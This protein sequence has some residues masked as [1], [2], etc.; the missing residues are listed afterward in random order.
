MK[1]LLSLTILTSLIFGQFSAPTIAPFLQKTDKAPAT[2]QPVNE[3]PVLNP[4]DNTSTRETA[5]PLVTETPVPATQTETPITTS[6]EVEVSM[7][8]LSVNPDFITPGGNLLLQW[9]IKGLPLNTYSPVLQITIPEGFSIQGKVEGEFDDATRILTI[10]VNALDGKIQLRA[11]P[12]ITDTTFYAVLLGNTTPLAE[13]KYFVPVHKQFKLDQRGGVIEDKEK[14]IKIEFPKDIFSE[15]T[16]VEIGAPSDEA[17]PVYS[18]L[19]RPF[20]IKAH[21]ELNNELVNK[22]DDFITLGVNYADLGIPENQAGDI[23]IAWYNEETDEWEALPSSVDKETQTVYAMTNHFTVFDI[24]VNTWQ[25]THVPTIDAFQVSNFTGAATYSLPI[26][27][28]PGPGGLQ[29]EVVLNYNSQVVDQSN[30]LAQA[31]WAGMGWS[32]DTG[33]IE[34]NT[35]GTY[36]TQDDTFFLNIR[37]VSSQ[38]VKDTSGNYHLSDENFWKVKFI[39]NPSSWELKDKT[40]NTYTFG[41]VSTM[42][43]NTGSVQG[44]GS[45]DIHTQEYRWDLTSVKNIF[46]KEIIY[47]YDKDTKPFK[48]NYFNDYCKVKSMPTDTAV[49][50]K[51]I[52]YANNRYQVRFELSSRSDYKSTWLSDWNHHSFMQR[53][54]S[55]IY[56]EQKNE[57]TGVFDI[58][59]RKYQLTYL[60]NNDPGIIWPGVNWSAGGKTATLSGVRQFGIGGSTALPG[61]TFTY[62]DNMHLT[63]A[64]NGYGGA[65]EFDY[66]LWEYRSNARNSQTVEIEFGTYGYPC[67]GNGRFTET[68]WLARPGTGSVVTCPGEDG[69]EDG[70]LQVRGIATAADIQ[71]TN[72]S[73]YG[74]NTS[75][76]LVRPGGMYK[77]TVSI[78]GMQSGMSKKVGLFDGTRDNLLGGGGPYFIQLPADASKVEPVVQITGGTASLGYFKF[79]LLTAVYRVQEKR[80]YDGIN[81]QPYRYT[82]DY[83]L[84]DVDSAKVNDANTSDGVCSNAEDC[85][86][87]TEQFSEF[88]GHGQVTETGPDGTKTITQFHQDDILK[89]R[90]VST[91]KKFD[92]ELLTSSDYHYTSV[93]LPIA[94]ITPGTCT[95]CGHFIGIYRNWIYTD[96][97]ENRV[98][99]INGTYNATKTNYTYAGTDDNLTPQTGYGNLIAQTEQAWDGSNWTPYRT[100]TTDYF[101]NVTNVTNVTNVYLTGLPARQQVKNTAGTVIAESLNIYDDNLTYNLTPTTGKLAAVRT[102]IN[103]SNYSQSSY[104]YDAWGNQDTITTYTGY[105]T[106]TTAPTV[107]AQTTSTT[108]DLNY[109][110]YP[111]TIS[112]ALLQTTT[113]T[114]DYTLGVPLTET[115]PNGNTT[116]AT[117]DVFG[118]MIKLIRPG[119]DASNPTIRIDYQDSF[120]FTSTITQK[121]D[122]TKFYTVQ[123]VYDGIG[124]QT[125]IISGPSTGSGQTIVD[126]IYQSPTVTQQSTPHFA[127]ET[128]Y[129]TTTTVDP[130]A[131]TTI[132]TAPD[133][134]STVSFTDGLVTTVTDAKGDKT[135]TSSDVWGRVLSVIPKDPQGNPFGPDVA[136]TYDELNRLKT[137]TRGGVTTVLDY[138]NAG[139]KI[140]MTDPD[141]GYWQYDYDALGSLTLQIDAR[142]QRICLYYDPLN[143]L[144]GKHYR[145]DDNCPTSPTLDVSYTYDSGA[146]GIGRRTGMIDTSGASAW[147]YDT[148]GRM[149]SE[150]K[151]ITSAGTFNTT[152]TY[153]SAD[154]PTGMTYPDGEMVTY[155]YNNR[156]LLNDMLGTDTYIQSTGYDS[157]GRMQTRTLGSGITQEYDYYAWDVS[158]QG[159]RLQNLTAGNLQS[160]T[161]IYDPVGNI[162]QIQDAVSSETQAFGYDALNRL[163]AAAVTNGPAPYTETYSYD[164]STGNLSAKAG[165]SYTYS[166][167]HPHAAQTLS[168]G[169]TYQYDANGNMITRSVDTLTF[170]LTYDAENRLVSVNSNGTP[171]PST[172]TPTPAPT[173]TIAPTA[174]VSPTTTSISTPTP[175]SP[176]L[177]QTQTL[178]NTATSTPISAPTTVTL[179]PNGTA[180][181]DTYILNALPTTNYGTD[182][183]M[184]VGEANIATNYIGRSLI[185]FDLSSIPSNASITSATLSLWTSTDYSSTTRTI[186][187]FRLKRA[188][189]ESQATWNI[190]STGTNWQTAGASGTNDR[191]SADIGSVQILSD[192]PLN[193]EKQITLTPA[194]IQELIAGTFTNNG[195]IIVSDT[196]LN[197]GFMYKTSDNVTSSQRPKLVIEYTLP[198]QGYNQ[199]GG[200][201]FASY[202]NSAPFAPFQQSGFPSAP[203]L[204]NFNRA[205]GSIG[206]NWS[207]ATSLY[208]I[209]SNQLLIG[210]GGYGS[211]LYWNPASFGADQEAYFTFT[212][213]N[214]SADAQGVGLKAQSNTG[215][216]NGLLAV[217]YIAPLSTVQVMTYTPIQGWVQSGSN[218]SASFS[219]GDQFGARA[220]ANGTVEVYKN[221]SL[222]G[223]RD[224]TAWPYYNSGGYI[225]MGFVNANGAKVDDFGGGNVSTS[226]TNTPTATPTYTP[227]NTP[228]A[229]NTPTITSTPTNTPLVTNTFTKTSTP[230]KTPTQTSTPTNTPSP[231][232]TAPNTPTSTATISQTPISGG[233]ACTQI[234]HGPVTV[235]GSSMTMEI[236]NQTGTPLSVQDVTITWNHDTGKSGGGPLAIQKSYLNSYIYWTGNN[237]PGPSLTYIPSPAM[238]IPTGASTIGAGFQYSYANMDGT[239]RIQINFSTPGCETYTFDSNSPSMTITP[240]DTFTPTAT[241]TLTFTPTITPTN[242]STPTSPPAS[243]FSSASFTYDGDGR[244]VKSVMTTD[245]GTTTTYFVS[246]YYEVTGGVITKYYYA[247]AQRIAMRE[248]GTLYYLLGDHLGST[249][250]TTFENGNLVSEMKYKAWGEVRY[251]SGVTPTDYTYTGQYSNTGDFGLMFYNARWY[252]PVLGR[253]NQPDTLIPE[254]SQ[255]VQAWDRFAYVNNNPISYNDPTGHCLG[256]KACAVEITKAVMFLAQRAISN[257]GLEDK[258]YRDA[259]NYAAPAV[260]DGSKESASFTIGMFATYVKSKTLITT[261]NGEVQ[262]FNESTTEAEIGDGLSVP[263]GGG[264]PGMGV[265]VTHGN[266]YGLDHALDYSNGATQLNISVPLPVCD[267]ACGPY[268]EGYVSDDFKVKGVDAGF[269]LGVGPTIIGGAHTDAT[270][271]DNLGGMIPAQLNEKQLLVCRLMSMCGAR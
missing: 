167:N 125:K 205:N 157:A 117:Y 30:S 90:P 206:A 156:M 120:P 9:G 193:T 54:L 7:L 75:K 142:G 43:Y 35:H 165:T 234:F 27:V 52:R 185:K 47:D 237:I 203:V 254:Q 69:D 3:T 171:P 46:S 216:G 100:T 173:E 4:K 50:P 212:Q 102:W 38:I 42:V 109:H 209:S 166:T 169:N 82:Y 110:T 19:G 97:V 114:Y 72:S 172:S 91:T 62:G 26:E 183:E 36:S 147:T 119:D 79:Q 57:I 134:T 200:F 59:V 67:S 164:P 34:R 88:R 44:C 208:G 55:A 18:L 111:V 10:P 13:T 151:T 132:M 5:I 28:P 104:G 249:S 154:L 137:A 95:A 84:N 61:Y 65:V 181:I 246:N 182:T 149:L 105:G 51:T 92:T 247:G 2:A 126:T 133:G 242:P 248:N 232:G 113:L 235:S 267:F 177:T 227:A 250:I 143:R 140:S 240:T 146:N 204:D 118:R 123:R 194:M 197:D 29:P 56:V 60:A 76:D 11:Q 159:G 184:G 121:I 202:R 176:T 222:L 112:N 257:S 130:A 198:G 24:D 153:N 186:R 160:L 1:T 228:I 85:Y 74:V 263:E 78:G 217:I 66:D 136:Y 101:P 236:N 49:Y 150:S 40:G 266:V 138:D 259:A 148:R 155:N 53:R 192:E 238:T 226:M 162:S 32:L 261:A 21:K 189:N 152:W 98:Y 230:S 215:W 210:S 244:R 37:G 175:V 107:G 63:R 268:F 187:I 81:I 233:P 127:G 174:T 271:T 218:I 180:G 144:T 161:Y 196:E 265:A 73:I 178:N 201:Q 214:S 179:Q 213:V 80:L 270:A 12:T 96:S 135:T 58:V 70:S 131:R 22:F 45:P 145:T 129:Y 220:R 211:D 31:S 15:K 122:D 191:E 221:G 243:V 108:Y 83:S 20:E 64:Q 251:A 89:G 41:F 25:A 128:A 229:S 219:I 190:A 241:N 68:P 207:G 255:G 141:M 139:R 94:L 195:F 48:W 223:T 124:R 199:N 258:D 23:Y 163:T 260:A 231:T 93:P 77:L 103:G 253:F 239:E 262:V 106:A 39:S 245:L 224:V 170:D 158:G 14:K 225:G 71:N 264:L 269:E 16:V 86:E 99:A 252:D 6:N 188:F 8:S 115:D 168:N 33:S 87:F 256:F 116:S 17:I